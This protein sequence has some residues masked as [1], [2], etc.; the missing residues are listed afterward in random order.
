MVEKGGIV[1]RRRGVADGESALIS[2]LEVR[3]AEEMIDAADRMRTRGSNLRVARA[4]ASALGLPLWGGGGWW[5]AFSSGVLS[6]A[7][8][9]VFGVLAGGVVWWIERAMIVLR[10]AFR[11]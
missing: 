4:G 9:G 6:V 2:R 5:V 8:E 11:E 3:D 1:R 10:S 7:E